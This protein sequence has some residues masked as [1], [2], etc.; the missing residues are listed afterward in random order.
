MRAFPPTD[1]SVVVLVPANVGVPT[2]TDPPANDPSSTDLPPVG[3]G[4]VESIMFEMPFD[5]PLDSIAVIEMVI[6]DA[7]QS[8]D[9]PDCRRDGRPMSTTR[10]S[11]RW[12]SMSR[13]DQGVLR[14]RPMSLP[15]QLGCSMTTPIPSARS[16]PA[17]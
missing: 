17:E 6:V 15:I 8:G 7:T 10:W 9:P 12:S 11:K 13:R 3:L 1:E 2:P 16:A 14:V 4:D 5:P